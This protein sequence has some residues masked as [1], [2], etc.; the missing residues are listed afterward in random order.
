MTFPRGL[1]LASLAAAAACGGDGG[2]SGPTVAQV[3]IDRSSVFLTAAGESTQ[4]TAVALDENDVP[5]TAEIVWSSTTPDQVSVD[6]SGT[7][8]AQTIG[9]AQIIAEAGGVRSLPA[10]VLVAEPAPG[11]ILVPDDQVVAIAAPTELGPDLPVMGTQYEVTLTGLAAPPEPGTVVLPVGDKVFGG[12]VVSS[13]AEGSNLV[14]TLALAP[15]YEL[16]ARYDFAWSIALGPFAAAQA[17]TTGSPREI[18]AP[19]AVRPETVEPFRPFSCDGSVEAG[20]ADRVTSVTPT[21]D[22]VLELFG[23]KPNADQPPSYTR[24]AVSGTLSLEGEVSLQFKPNISANGECLAQYPI[25]VPVGGLLAL[26]VMPQVRIGVGAG[27]EASLV[28]AEG[29]VGLKGTLS[30]TVAVGIECGGATP[31]CRPVET[32]STSHQLRPVAEIPR[33]DQMHVEASTQVFAF[34][35]LDALFFLTLNAPIAEGRFGPKQSFD[36]G[37]EKDQLTNPDYASSYQL[38]LEGEV[39]PGRALQEA[40]NA[41]FPGPAAVTFKAKASAPISH[42]P[43]GTLSVDK[44]VTGPLQPVTISVD[45]SDVDYWVL[46]YNVLEVHIYKKREDQSEFTQLAVIPVSASG[47]QTHFQHVWTPTE[48]DVGK[49]DIA[50]LVMTQLD[51]LIPLHEIAADSR[52][53]VDVK[54]FSAPTGLGILGGTCE[55][56]WSGTATYRITTPGVPDSW[57]QT[58]AN[59]RWEAVEFTP[60]PPFV[61]YE[62]TG[63]LTLETSLPDGCTQTNVP[64][65]F[66]FP[67]TNPLDAATFG[68]SYGVDPFQYGFTLQSL[69]DFTST[70]TCP[71]EDPVVTENQ[72]FPLGVVGNGAFVTPDDVTISGSFDDGA[73]SGSFSFTRL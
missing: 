28:V 18:A 35:G 21:V 29:K 33:L 70:V 52:K 16:L 23:Q 49:N 72:G 39:K 15:L 44:A 57:I 69:V 20:L 55:D 10:L 71:G 63:T 40:I 3:V 9:S 26:L 54:C 67:G 6:A 27:V 43:Q 46:D 60:V 47:G 68:I 48:A 51:P 36:M 2:P 62:A 65:V 13:R 73:V 41:I 34:V 59:L 50:A 17:A 19:L 64:S 42:S 30:A 56:A 4:L 11:A 22:L 45:L 58:T 66:T 1:L 14:V 38:A 32:F 8:V 24:R 7:V 31:D 12:K 37:M 25:R 61:R 53:Q 5:V